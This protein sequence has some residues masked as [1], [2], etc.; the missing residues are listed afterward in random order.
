MGQQPVAA[1][2]HYEK[3]KAYYATAT[4]DCVANMATKRK[5]NLKHRADYM[6]TYRLRRSAAGQ[7]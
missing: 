2:T 7:S 3:H 6:R 1:E 5:S 4:S